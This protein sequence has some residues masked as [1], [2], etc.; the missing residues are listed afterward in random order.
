L[1]N[2]EDLPVRQNSTWLVEPTKAKKANEIKHFSA[3]VVEAT[4]IKKVNEIEAFLTRSPGRNNAEKD[5]KLLRFFGYSG[6]ILIRE[7]RPGRQGPA[8]YA[9]ASRRAAHV[10]TN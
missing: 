3:L 4:K 5:N 8:N 2:G 1:E 7:R 10:G 6:S 9:A